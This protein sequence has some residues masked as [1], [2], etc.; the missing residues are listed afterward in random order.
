M[1]QVL[2]LMMIVF[3]FIISTQS[4]LNAKTL[5][6][7]DFEKDLSNWKI[8]G[9]NVTIVE[10]DTVKGNHVL[11]FNGANQSIVAKNDEFRELKDYIIEVKARAVEQLQWTEVVILFRVQGD[12]SKYYQ[13]Y[14]NVH[15]PDTNTVLNNGAAFTN[16]NTVK[17]VPVKIGQWFNKK[18][19]IEGD[20]IQVF[21]DDILYIDE[22]R[23]DLDKG[24]FG[25]RSATV[26]VQYDNWHVYDLSGPSQNPRAVRKENK[27]AMTWGSIKR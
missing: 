22:K 1:K 9:G 19:R 27:L 13:A 17:G 14:T 24:T 20:E 12:N 7:D 26:H 3:V 15:I 25:S 23:S 10:D 11:D 5:F 2:S 8:L 16:F 4:I 21:I 18:V 6:F